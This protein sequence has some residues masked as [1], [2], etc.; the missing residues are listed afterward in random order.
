LCEWL[1]AIDAP[2]T[3]P[4]GRI[5]FL[6][7]GLTYDAFVAECLVP[8]GDAFEETAVVV[9]IPNEDAEDDQPERA[10]IEQ[11]LLRRIRKHGFPFAVP[12]PLGSIRLDSGVAVIQELL[13][14]MPVDL[15]WTKSHIERPWN[16]IGEVA[17]AV[18]LLPREPFESIIGGSETRREHAEF[19]LEILEELD[20]PE[21]AMAREWAE[22]HLPPETPSRVLHGDLLG[23]NILV[24][25]EGL[26]GVID[27]TEAFFGDPAFDIAIVTRGVKKPFQKGGGHRLLLE[28]YN[29]RAPDFVSRPEVHLHEICL[30]AAWYVDAHDS[31]PGTSNTEEQLRFLRALLRR[32]TD[33][34]P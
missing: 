12:R 2:V 29:E 15:R 22:R 13:P 33:R 34:F 6:G 18:H 4:S 14:G 5:R 7:D 30:A 21:F 26:T 17:A 9:R 32:V 23:Q 1:E 3:E 24:P 20:I 8:R 19:E 31:E 28:A 11:R 27:W 10:A 25:L 16:L